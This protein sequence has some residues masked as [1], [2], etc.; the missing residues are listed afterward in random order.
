MRVEGTVDRDFGWHVGVNNSWSTVASSDRLEQSQ[1]VRDSFRETER[2][3]RVGGVGEEQ[4]PDRE[5]GRELFVAK[6]RPRCS[7]ERSL[8]KPSRSLDD[9][10]AHR[11]MRF[12]PFFLKRKGVARQSIG[13]S[14]LGHVGVTTRFS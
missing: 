7:A 2:H 9:Q 5:G 1:R 4:S 8:R 13:P 11:A 3:K 10:I 6:R 14:A 12:T